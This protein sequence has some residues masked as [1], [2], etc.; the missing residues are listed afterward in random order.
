MQIKLVGWK[1]E[2]FRCPD[3]D[4]D[5]R[6]GGQVPRVSLIQMPNGT[7][8]T[9]TLLLL[10]AALTGNASDWD[11]EKIEQF[12]KKDSSVSKGVFTVD[13]LIDGSD[14]TFELTLDFSR[15]T[16][17]YRTSHKKAGGV[18]RGWK[19]PADA[20]KFLTDQFIRLFLFDGELAE[21]LLESGEH[22][23]EK[24]IDALFQL[25][26]FRSISEKAEE[27][28]EKETETKSGKTGQAE[29]L[30]RNKLSDLRK[31]LMKVERAKEEAEQRKE[32]LEKAVEELESNINGRIDKVDRLRGEQEDAQVQ[33]DRAE[34]EVEKWRREL[35]SKLRSPA[36]V[37]KS[38]AEAIQS[39][40]GSL[41][42]LKL[43]AN[44]T[45]Q[46]FLELVEQEECICGEDLDE[47]ARQTILEKSEEFLGAETS[48][49]INSLKEDI[50][51]YIGEDP[52]E[53]PAEAKEIAGKLT[54]AMDNRSDASGTLRAIREQ[55][56]EEGDEKVEE[57]ENK[58]E[59]Y[60]EEISD[61]SRFLDR[62]NGSPT[63]ED[64]DDP[65]T[66]CLKAIRDQVQGA[67]ES[68]AEI[69]Q[70]LKLR[71]QIDTLQTILQEAQEN[72]RKQLKE[73]IVDEC[74]SR[75]N[76]ILAFNPIEISEISGSLKLKNQGGA[77]VGQTLAVA[78]TFLTTL[79]GRGQ[80]QFPL[81]VDSPANPID[82]TVR[83]QVASVI[84]E[85]TDQFVAFT[86]SSERVGFTDH[87]HR[88]ADGDVRYL[89]LFR[90][91]VNTDYLIGELPDTG[92]LQTDD[93]VLVEG[94]DYFN[95]FD[96]KEIEETA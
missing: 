14:L 55:L 3:I 25:Y 5:L 24:A 94:R 26:L 75:L 10:K 12:K 49:F 48:G 76:D 68:V 93:G 58:K 37:D 91:N 81:I 96:D 46:F 90:K 31:H 30:R 18:L 60:E 69:T 6:K 88:S 43:P 66:L 20:R 47:Q 64:K 29:A 50:E 80:H 84:P 40:K 9:T 92:V 23:A 52:E 51:R 39:L 4:V 56:I 8:K 38:F 77:S 34:Q 95:K 87:L 85:L 41:D 42:T 53:A 32:K 73:D 15:G 63:P 70:T 62:V 13:L 71:E 17:R 79:L 89:T 7:G 35:L 61:L 82:N 28:W 74:R 11:T 44:T 65:E 1:A 86:I 19:P 54:S 72:A 83:S 33:L 2:G 78:Y 27:R 57:W 45:R 22:E 16:V 36:A 21:R 59:E 67:K